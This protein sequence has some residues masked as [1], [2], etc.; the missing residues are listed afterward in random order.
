MTGS[1]SPRLNE[2]DVA[3]TWEE[4]REYHLSFPLNFMTYTYTIEQNNCRGNV[5][6]CWG[7]RDPVIQWWHWTVMQLKH[8]YQVTACM[9]CSK[10]EVCNSTLSWLQREWSRLFNQYAATL[11]AVN[12]CRVSLNTAW[13]AKSLLEGSWLSFIIVSL[14]QTLTWFVTY[15]MAPWD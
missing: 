3:W 14:R 13:N 2:L 12:I 7:K 6:H 8:Q 10:N 9:A 15:L 4:E 1:S 11:A 5:E